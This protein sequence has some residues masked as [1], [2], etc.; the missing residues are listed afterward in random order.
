MTSIKNL[1]CL[2][3]FTSILNGTKKMLME[4]LGTT[5]ELTSEVDCTESR[6]TVRMY[7]PTQQGKPQKMYKGKIGTKKN[8]VQLTY[9]RAKTPTQETFDIGDQDRLHPV[10]VVEPAK[11]KEL[12][13][14]K[15][16]MHFPHF[17]DL[18]TP[19][20]PTIFFYDY[21]HNS[22]VA[23]SPTNLPSFLFKCV[24]EITFK[25]HSSIRPDHT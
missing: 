7:S 16:E 23:K 24:C 1:R 18:A 17:I 3:S 6:I 22:L 12:I 2:K 21:Y 4:N 8:P 25:H 14:K 13:K 19:P 20:H 10:S 11:P 9:I 5:S 15:V